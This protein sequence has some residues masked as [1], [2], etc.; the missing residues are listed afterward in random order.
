MIFTT[1]AFIR[2]NAPDIALNITKLGYKFINLS[3]SGNY[4]FT[5][6]NGEAFYANGNGFGHIDCG[7]NEALFLAIA[8][9]RDDSD[10]M[11]WFIFEETISNL[12]LFKQYNKGDFYLC[13]KDKMELPYSK[14]ATI[15]E[16]IEHF[17]N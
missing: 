7:T 8:A 11:Q 2:K 15:Q 5:N 4:I 1:S 17:N 14:K 6:T 12:R 13:T 10:Y 16:L 9:L 3:N